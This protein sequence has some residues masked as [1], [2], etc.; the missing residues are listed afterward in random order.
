MD[1][2]EF[3]KQRSSQL[4]RSTKFPIKVL[5][6]DFLQLCVSLFSPSVSF[7]REEY[8]A[9]F[10]SD[11]NLHPEGHGSNLHSEE[12]WSPLDGRTIEG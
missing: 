5:E 3:Q 7:G 10:C 6:Q 9:L 12:E 11:S 8:V 4:R 2:E 1:G